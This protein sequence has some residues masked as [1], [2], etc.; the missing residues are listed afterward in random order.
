MCSY[1]KY[2]Q[3][4]FAEKNEPEFV[5][6]RW[7]DRQTDGHKGVKQYNPSPSEGGIIKLK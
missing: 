5:T 2:L 4:F 6:C 7:T 1:F 3:L